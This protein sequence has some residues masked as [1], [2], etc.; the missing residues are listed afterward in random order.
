[1]EKNIQQIKRFNRFYIRM[2]GLFS[3]YNDVSSYSAT[4]AMILYE[5]NHKK[6]CTASYLADYYSFDK[7]YISRIISKFTRNNVVTKVPSERD[8]RIQHLEMTPKG[9]EVLD[10]LATKANA[11][12]ARMIKDVE[13]EDVVELIQAMTQI[14]K[15]L[16]KNNKG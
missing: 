1:M 9:K 3:L 2:M 7:G 16:N 14:E 11:N 5:I 10:E 6:N 12:V 15:I 8:R 13:K 4:E